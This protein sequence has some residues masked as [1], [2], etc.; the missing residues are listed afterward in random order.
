[1]VELLMYFE[2]IWCNCGN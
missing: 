1:M 2:S